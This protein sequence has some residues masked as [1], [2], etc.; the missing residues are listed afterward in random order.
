[1]KKLFTEVGKAAGGTGLGYTQ[2][3]GGGESDKRRNNR[4]LSYANPWN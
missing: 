4:V 3:K 2:G 1:M